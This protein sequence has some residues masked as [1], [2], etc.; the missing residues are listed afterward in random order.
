MILIT[1][2]TGFVG[3]HLINGLS[4]STCT[5]IKALT[6]K[7]QGRFNDSDIVHYV[8]G[9]ISDKA[10]LSSFIEPNSTV[11]NL[12]YANAASS[13]DAIDAVKLMAE[14][15]AEKGIKR[16]VHCSS[17]SVYGRVNG[18]ITESTAC[19]P[20][21]GY[22]QIKLATEQALIEHARGKFELII[23]RP[24][25]VFGSGGKTLMALMRSLSE[26]NSLV[27]YA[28]STLF[29][30]RRMHLVPVEMLVEAIQFFCADERQYDAEVFNVSADE[31]ALNQFDKLEQLLRQEMVL[32]NYV[33]P[34]FPMP[35]VVFK[36]A[37]LLAGRPTI[38]HQVIYSSEKL[39][40]HGFIS[41]C[42]FAQALSKLARTNPHS[43][44]AGA[45]A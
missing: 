44:V 34:I 3:K 28:R 16:F 20:P 17:I 24:S 9:D 4:N 18:V 31:H 13:K 15:C 2:A 36:S 8:D 32:P 40:K 23:L 19:T 35:S 41:N 14:L 43:K 5:P 37:L 22:G 38:D 39:R 33:L 29:G 7:K 12:A 6:R 10:S 21:D 27:N 30:K 1:G 42:D 26:R 11:I 45:A 25:E